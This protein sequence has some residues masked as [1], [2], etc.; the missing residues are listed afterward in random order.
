MKHLP[1]NA[2][3]KID[4]PKGSINGTNLPDIPVY[5]PSITEFSNFYN[6]IK[7]IEQL[8]AHHVGLC[9]II[10]PKE[11]KPRSSPFSELSP[12]PTIE[13]PIIQSC[14]GYQG[15]YLQ[16]ADPQPDLSYDD[17]KYKHA[18]SLLSS[19]TEANKSSFWN[20]KHLLERKTLYGA[21]I[22][23]TLTDSKVRAFNIGKLGSMIEHIFGDTPISG[24]NTPYLYFGSPFSS[25]A[26]HVEDAELY[27]INYL[28]D[29]SSKVWYVIPPAFA[30]RFEALA[31]EY[32]RAEYQVCSEFLRHKSVI[33]H[34]DILEAA[35]IPVKTIVQHCNEIIITFPYGYHS[36]FNTGLNVAESTNFA[37]PRWLPYMIHTKF[38]FC[39]P[40]TVRF[41]VEQAL[42]KIGLDST[43]CPPHPLDIYKISE[44]PLPKTAASE[45]HLFLHEGVSEY[46][47]KLSFESRRLTHDHVDKDHLTLLT[48]CPKSESLFQKGDFVSMDALIEYHRRLCSMK[49]YCAV[50]SF[51]VP[52]A[53]FKKRMV[54]FK[55]NEAPNR[56]KESEPLIPETAYAPM[57]PSAAVQLIKFPTNLNSPLITCFVCHL[58][59]HARCYGLDEFDSKPTSSMH[60]GWLCQSCRFLS[61]NYKRPSCTLCHFRGG[62]LVELA[63]GKDSSKDINERVFIHLICALGAPACAFINIPKRI[64]CL[65]PLDQPPKISPYFLPR[66]NKST[67]HRDVRCVVCYL[68]P[69]GNCSNTLMSCWKHSTYYCHA[70]CAQWKGILVRLDFLPWTIHITCPRHKCEYDSPENRDFTDEVL[71]GLKVV[72]VDPDLGQYKMGVA[73][74]R[75]SEPTVTLC[76]I[77]EPSVV[78]TVN[79]DKLKKYGYD[80]DLLGAPKS[81]QRVE[82]LCGRLGTSNFLSNEARNLINSFYVSSSP[83]NWKVKIGN[84]A[85]IIS[86]YEFYTRMEFLPDHVENVFEEADMQ[87]NK[88]K[89]SLYAKKKAELPF[90]KETTNSNPYIYY[91]PKRSFKIFQS[92]KNTSPIRAAL[93]SNQAQLEQQRLLKFHKSPRVKAILEV[94]HDFGGETVNYESEEED[95]EP[96]TSM[97]EIPAN[98]PGPKDL[99]VV[100]NQQQQSS[101]ISSTAKI[102][103]VM[104]PG[105]AKQPRVVTKPSKPCAILRKQIFISSNI[106]NRIAKPVN[107][108]KRD[109]PSEDGQDDGPMLKKNGHF[110]I[111]PV[112]E[113]DL[114]VESKPRKTKESQGSPDI[115]EILDSDGSQA[116]LPIV[117]MEEIIRASDI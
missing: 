79:V 15:V 71:T 8:G 56:P 34:P 74:D 50:C 35:K 30:R 6:C 65:Y 92:K 67:D 44:P 91:D 3:S 14:I 82:T 39:W 89:K 107:S 105:M 96:G 90:L 7:Q 10:P 22:P 42:K 116:E 28:H 11:W 104:M 110:T 114:I 113:E 101:N 60:Q 19:K 2:S 51:C 61:I 76:N 117:N 58:T 97:D 24:V 72:V 1:L 78:Y 16:S 45:V 81:G 86:R 63:T 33:I 48:L 66:I 37:L 70:T 21:N 59:V 53:L 62:A 75:F 27:S 102:D 112:S 69:F 41:N 52:P 17:F 106:L 111:G 80:W 68:K 25:F 29:G 43:Y 47:K 9:K 93:M 46:Y 115:I 12:K 40:D 103:R 77:Q 95:E 73:V 108:G 85:R 4:F 13:S 32:F 88:I 84:A 36:G 26:W 100:N 23:G 64:P 55:D 38:C 98:Q 18:T 87:K 99:F 54:K 109:L 83:E 94:R 57:N 20:E 5:R 49:P 31:K